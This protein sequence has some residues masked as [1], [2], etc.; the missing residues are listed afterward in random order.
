MYV[1]CSKSSIREHCMLGARHSSLALMLTGHDVATSEVSDILWKKHRFIFMF[2]SLF[3]FEVA[4]REFQPAAT[5]GFALFCSYE[6][7]LR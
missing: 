7:G 4:V 1:L 2:M 5:G 3:M 6:Q